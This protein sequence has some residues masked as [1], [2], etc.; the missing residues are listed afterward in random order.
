M[1]TS[2]MNS[3]LLCVATVA[4]SVFGS[5][6]VAGGAVVTPLTGALA[7]ADLA[8]AVASAPTRSWSHLRLTRA[9]SP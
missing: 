2:I 8:A 9:A 4:V 1:K 7:S 5:L 6:T 3:K